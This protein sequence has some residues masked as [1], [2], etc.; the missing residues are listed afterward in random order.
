MHL[1]L[2][3]ADSYGIYR[4]LRSWIVSTVPTAAPTPPPVSTPILSEEILLTTAVPAIKHI[5]PAEA[6]AVIVAALPAAT[7]PATLPII[8]PRL[9]PCLALLKIFLITIFPSCFKS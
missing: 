5:A 7:T 1:T 4:R 9:A 6:G 3:I 8:P 2:L